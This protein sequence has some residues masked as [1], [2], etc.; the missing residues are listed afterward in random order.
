MALEIRI[1][2]GTLT[3]PVKFSFS[4]CVRLFASSLVFNNWHQ[5][6]IL[7]QIVDLA[8]GSITKRWLTISSKEL[9]HYAT[10][11]RNSAIEWH[12]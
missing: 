8:R 3:R 7:K 12:N 10:Y 5:S 1:H 6:Y 9:P 11:L 4:K 2:D